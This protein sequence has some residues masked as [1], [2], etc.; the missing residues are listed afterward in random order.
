[1]GRP[2][3]DCGPEGSPPVTPDG[4]PTPEGVALTTFV[5]QILTIPLRALVPSPG[6]PDSC[7]SSQPRG[8]MRRREPLETMPSSP[9]RQ[10]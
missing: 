5:V 6:Y 3:L 2:R 7:P 1:V 10:A 8:L 4:R 9:V